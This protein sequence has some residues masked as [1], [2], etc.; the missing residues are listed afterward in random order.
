MMSVCKHVRLSGT[1]RVPLPSAEAFLLFTP[2]GERAWVEGW[3][4][5]FPSNVADETEPGTVFETD[6][7]GVQTTWVVVRSEHGEM[8]EYAGSRQVIEPV[9]S[10]S[11]V[12][13]SGTT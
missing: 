10:A 7:G 9:W 5:L 1:I 13:L 2:S 8:I 3:D 11:P 6:H 12:Q 4:P